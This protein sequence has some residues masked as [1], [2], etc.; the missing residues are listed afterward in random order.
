[1]KFEKVSLETFIQEVKNSFLPH[2]RDS[3]N[4]ELEAVYN[5][6]QLPKRSTSGSA[7]YDFINPFDKV[8]LNTT[9]VE[10]PTG[11]KV[12]LDPDKILML[13]PRSSSA[14]N[15][16]MFSN[17]LGIVDSDYYNNPTNEGCIRVSLKA[18]GTSH[19]EFES[20]DKIAQGIILQYFITEDDNATGTRTGGHGS[21]G[22]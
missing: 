4:E 7:G 2:Y 1:M 18:M 19:P 5:K 6:I 8:V 17:T 13:A 16:Y 10:I 12:K 3:S 20:G 9:N 22:K 11:I 21:T 15:G 14:R